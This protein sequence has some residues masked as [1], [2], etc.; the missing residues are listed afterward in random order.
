MAL[1]DL[2]FKGVKEIEQL[3]KK[4]FNLPISNMEGST[5][6]DFIMVVAFKRSKLRLKDESVG[7]IL[8]ACFRGTPIRFKTSRLMNLSFKFCVSSRHV[9]FAIL[10]GGNIA[11]HLFNVEF[12]LGNGGPNSV[13]EYWNYLHEQSNEWTVINRGN[14][15]K[16]SYAQVVQAPRI[17]AANSN[18]VQ[19][20]TPDSDPAV[21]HNG[22]INQATD[23][24][25][26]S[27]NNVPLGRGGYLARNGQGDR[28]GVFC[29]R[30]LSTNHS[31][32]K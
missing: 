18:S 13:R 24:A 5:H 31:R 10:R 4:D 28:S 8:Q 32:I 9:G 20:A 17:M 26:T 2:N 1:S 15:N 14:N 6:C 16:R 21:T 25:L 3:I 29:F 23:G 30:C 27:P 12:F 7:L 19:R 11:N 22:V